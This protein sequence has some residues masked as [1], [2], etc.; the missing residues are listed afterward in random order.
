MKG[1]GWLPW[2][3]TPTLLHLFTHRIQLPDLLLL[4]FQAGFTASPSAAFPLAS[5]RGGGNNINLNTKL[6]DNFIHTHVTTSQI[7]SFPSLK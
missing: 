5:P 7:H 4:A 6:Y 1:R 3:W 2:S